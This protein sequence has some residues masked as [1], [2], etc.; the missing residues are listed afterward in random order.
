MKDAG[1]ANQ[2]VDMP[3]LSN[4]PLDHRFRFG[5]A[6]D[7]RTDPE[8]AVPECCDLLNNVR[9]FFLVAAVDHD[10]GTLTR[11]TSRD[12]AADS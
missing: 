3:K 8:R 7:V 10:V 4:R 12:G 1:V 5:E 11:K 9:D 2:D 6:A